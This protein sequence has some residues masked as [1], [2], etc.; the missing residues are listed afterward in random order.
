MTIAELE[1][2][3]QLAGRQAALSDGIINDALLEEAFETMRLG[4]VKGGRTDPETLLRTARHEA[5]HCLIGWHQ[6]HKPVQITIVARGQAGGYFEQESEENRQI[7]TKAE[8]EG[9]IRWYMGGRAAEILFYGPEEGL[10]SGVG[11]D[12]KRATH[13]AE[14]MVRDFGM[15]P[16]IGLVALA[17][18]RPQDGPLALAV[19]QAVN[20]IIQNQL[21]RAVDELA[22]QRPVLARLVGR[23]LEKNRLVREEL[24]EIFNS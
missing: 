5:G 7:Y 17:E 4:A 16:E 21:Q 9:I 6:G 23:L 20:S 24:E 22:A 11:S 8:L 1:R 15:S 2:I 12:L 14:L 13:I 10:A 19:N 3:I 18:K